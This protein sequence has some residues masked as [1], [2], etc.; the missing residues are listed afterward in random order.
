[1]LFRSPTFWPARV[2]NQVLT[3]Q[4]YMIVIDPNQ[5]M[6]NRTAAFARRMDW[7][8]PLK[9]PHSANTVSD[10]MLRMVEIFGSMGVLESRPGVPNS[11]VF[12]PTMMVASFGPKVKHAAPKNLS[13]DGHGTEVHPEPKLSM[14]TPVRARRS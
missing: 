8:E 5:T 14:P 3:E 10:Q 1:M 13:S 6:D 12:P 9:Q 7:N 11:S 2:P 4:D